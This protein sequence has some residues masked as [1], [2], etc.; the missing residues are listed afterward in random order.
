MQPL[1]AGL[2]NRARRYTGKVGNVKTGR[3]AK[4]LVIYTGGTIGM[5]H[6]DPT[7]LSSPLRPGTQAELLTAARI[8]NPLANIAWDMKPLTD[9]DRN[10]VGALDSSSV[11]PRE[12]RYMAAQIARN[13]EDY[14]GFVI[15]HGTDTMAYTASAL[16]FLLENLSKPVIM[17]GSQL[18]IA[19]VR[20]DG[21]L[22]L[23]NALYIAGYKST[24]LPC[25]P[26]VAICFADVL[27]R[28]NRTTKVSTSRWQGF[29]TPNYPH[30]GRIGESIEI[31]ET[32][33]LARPAGLFSAHTALK[34]SVTTITLYPGMSAAL[35]SNMLNADAQGFILRSF[36]TGAVIRDA[37][38]GGKIVVNTTQCLEGSVAM[39]LYA[40]SSTLQ[41]AGVIS[42][43]DLTQEAAL[44][45]LM[46]LLATDGGETVAA[47]MQTSQRGEQSD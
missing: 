11:G 42:G 28:G 17:T 46:W 21:G 10:S 14:D 16:S 37:V 7:D 27:L 5:V 36:G 30:L 4:V 6:T 29:D 39:G 41:A 32:V 47:R 15:L 43:A 13:Y 19:D 20:T 26:E 23:I 35:L 18:P 44:T 33:L 8:G 38:A 34:E 12:W 3:K 24:G 25:V 9:F 22:N 45:K 40:A 2:R 1:P 31:D